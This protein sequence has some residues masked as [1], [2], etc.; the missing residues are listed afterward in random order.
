MDKKTRRVLSLIAENP[1]QVGTEIVAVYRPAGGMLRALEIE[2]MIEYNAGWVLTK[3]GK[4]A[5]A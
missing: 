5:L 4:K 3:A 1:G 2:G